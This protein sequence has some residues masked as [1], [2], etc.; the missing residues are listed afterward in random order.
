MSANDEKEGIDKVRIVLNET[1]EDILSKGY[2]PD[3]LSFM[4]GTAL[5][6]AVA[7]LKKESDV[8]LQPDEDT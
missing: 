7:K 8:S 5:Y 6:P 4:I 3:Y 1:E 2:E